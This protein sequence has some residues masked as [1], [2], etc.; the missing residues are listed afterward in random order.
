MSERIRS[1]RASRGFSFIEILVV[2]GI[3]AVL[4][5]LGIGVYQLAIKKV[6]ITKCKALL[7]TM[8]TNLDLWKGKYK[9]YP[10]SQFSKMG[11]TLGPQIKVGKPTPSNT[12]NDGIESAFQAMFTPGFGHNP[13]LDDHRAN[14]DNDVLDKPF[15]PSGDPALYEVKDPWG[16]PLVYFTDADYV[17]AERTPPAYIGH[18]DHRFEPKPWRNESGGFAQTNGY[19]LFSIG[20]DEEPNT[21]DDLKAW[22]ND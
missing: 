16:N 11:I 12:D 5:G 9:A 8:R 18:D 6:P 17:A 21:D 4:V 14:Y 22:S 15:S 1:S 10:P 7:G 19:Q 3:I 20:P 2:M 13:D